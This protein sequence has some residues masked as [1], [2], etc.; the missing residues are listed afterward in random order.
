GL[1][2]IAAGHREVIAGF[3]ALAAVLGLFLLLLPP[4]GTAL[5]QD[6]RHILFYSQDCKHCAEIKKELEAGK[7]EFEPVLIKEY[8]ATLRPLGIEEVP[9]LLVTGPYEKIFLTGTKAIRRYLASCSAESAV[10]AG[11]KKRSPAAAA[12]NQPAG[13]LDL[14]IFAPAGSPNDILNPIPDEGLCKEDV[15]CD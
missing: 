13:Q 8:S 12:R 9:T 3:G 11:A 5:P 14:R 6:S 10:A 2:R 15:K 4:G 7:V 1:L